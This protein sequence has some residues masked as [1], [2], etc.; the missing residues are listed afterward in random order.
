MSAQYSENE[1]LEWQIHATPD[2][3]A[4]PQRMV[5]LTPNVANTDLPLEIAMLLPT[6]SR[7]RQSLHEGLLGGLAPNSALGLCLIDPFLHL[8]TLMDRMFQHGIGWVSN[9]PTAGQYDPAFE[10]F[11]DDVDL[12][13]AMEMSRLQK[14]KSH[15]FRTLAV[16]SQ[17]K[18]IAALLDTQPDAIAFVPPIAAFFDGLPSLRERQQQELAI[19]TELTKLGWSGPFLR[20]RTLPEHSEENADFLALLRPV[21]T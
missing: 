5:A 4:L 3:T 7:N 9:F 1:T 19:E 8:E 11:L 12:G 15:G 2:Q 16:L 17:S 20:Y 18:Q 21:T 6:Q 13:F 14:L 10:S